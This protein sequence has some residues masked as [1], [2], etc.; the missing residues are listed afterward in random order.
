MPK[1]TFFNLPTEKKQK[2][3]DALKREF[4]N[5]SLADASI[6]NIINYAQIPRGSFYQYFKNKDDAFFYLF[7]KQTNHAMEQFIWILQKHDGN[8]F[9]TATAFYQL[10]IEERENFTFFKNALL[11][12]N[13][14][15]EESLTGIF[16]SRDRMDHFKNIYHKINWSL[17][18]I[19]SEE[20]LFQLMK[21]ISAVTFHNIVEKF[22]KDLPIDVSIRNYNGQLTLIRNGVGS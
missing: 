10:I 7:D 8:L 9:D 13:Y 14:K 11:N 18:T 19:Q 4:S 17:L 3:I 5:T 6:A 2:L 21:M 20:E 1:E 22:S 16:A 12:M 15:I